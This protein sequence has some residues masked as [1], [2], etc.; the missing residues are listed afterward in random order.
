MTRLDL[1]LTSRTSEVSDLG[2]VPGADHG[3]PAEGKEQGQRMQDEA[4]QLH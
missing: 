1:C 2:H 4:A 3:A